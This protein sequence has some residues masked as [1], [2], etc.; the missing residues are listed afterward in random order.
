MTWALTAKLQWHLSCCVCCTDTWAHTMQRLKPNCGEQLVYVA[1]FAVAAKIVYGDQPKHDTYSRLKEFTSL[2]DLDYAFGI[3]A[4][5][6]R[7][8][9]HTH[10]QLCKASS[11]TKPKSVPYF[12][13]RV[14]CRAC[15][16]FFPMYCLLSASIGAQ[17]WWG[18]SFNPECA[19]TRSCTSSTACQDDAW[20]HW[21]HADK[22]MDAELAELPGASD[23]Q[24]WANRTCWEDGC[25]GSYDAH[26]KGG[27][28]LSD[29]WPG[30]RHRCMTL[31]ATP[32]A[33][34][35]ELHLEP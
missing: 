13:V 34:C 14:P 35:P 24:I 12:G 11:M 20:G 29:A 31:S 3:Q 16:I 19:A 30:C 1:A 9:A 17:Q 6:S 22:I 33:R 5:P 21:W 8:K 27:D 23:R 2:S 28:L 32:K 25:C 18:N 10:I 7:F 4:R 15:P 26:R